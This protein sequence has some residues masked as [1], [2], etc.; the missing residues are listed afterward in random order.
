MI[1]SFFT[2][3]IASII[4]WIPYMDPPSW[5]VW[6]NWYLSVL[7][8]HQTILHRI[9]VQT[10]LIQGASDNPYHKY[11]YNLK[12]MW[13]GLSETLVLNVV[14]SSSKVHIWS[15][16]VWSNIVCFRLFPDFAR[17]TLNTNSDIT[18]RLTQSFSLPI[19]SWDK[20]DST[21]MRVFPFRLF[22]RENCLC[23]LSRFQNLY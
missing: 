6:T 17:E 5:L 1:G 16:W 4:F 12:N 8:C 14:K 7:I 20:Q 18:V 2:S 13:Y 21:E 10:N 23:R 9:S 11:E 15:S 3:K 22:W 19:K